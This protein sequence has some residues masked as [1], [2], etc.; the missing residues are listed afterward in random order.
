MSVIQYLRDNFV[1]YLHSRGIYFG[2][3][4][5]TTTASVQE[6]SSDCSNTESANIL[7]QSGRRMGLT[8]VLIA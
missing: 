1:E 3:A 5:S 6:R 7:K 2:W 4:M 8:A